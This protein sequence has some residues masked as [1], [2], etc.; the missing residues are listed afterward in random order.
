MFFLI[1]LFILSLVPLGRTV[2]VMK[3][4]FFE[5]V[6]ANL[7]VFIFF[8]KH[9]DLYLT[10]RTEEDLNEVILRID[11][12]FENISLVALGN[13]SSQIVGKRVPKILFF[14]QHNFTKMCFDFRE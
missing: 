8:D 9:G 11:K 1:N 2:E 3:F 7:K 5:N 4:K 14:T 10:G 13:S 6:T 12:Y